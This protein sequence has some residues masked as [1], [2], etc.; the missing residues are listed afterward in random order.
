VVQKALAGIG[1]DPNNV[2]A[3]LEL[4]EYGERMSLIV[5]LPQNYWFD[6]GDGKPMALRLECRNSVDGSTR[7]KAFLGWFRFVCSNGLV[8]GITRFDVRRR[9]VGDMALS[10]IGR[11]LAGGI[12]ASE[13][14]KRNFIK[15]RD[16]SVE[17]ER[18]RV[19]AEKDLRKGWG[20]KAAARAWNI[21]KTGF[22]ANIVG[23]YKG[24]SPTTI[25][26]ENAS[27]VP[28]CPPQAL[29]L[30]DIS[31]ILAWLARDRRDLEEQL[32]WREQ[33]SGLLKPLMN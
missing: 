11:A 5:F 22:D 28:G 26:V 21:A 2:S 9:H 4:T 7:F 3:D 16:K 6:P 24:N 29:N 23:P 17:P 31:Q 19:W 14:E 8:I 32:Q 1:Q 27:Y 25:E 12:K 20:F 33:I 15:W 18:I 10:D 30:Y 13:E